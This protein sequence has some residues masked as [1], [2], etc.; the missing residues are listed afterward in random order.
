VKNTVPLIYD[1]IEIPYDQDLKFASF[2]INN[3]YANVPMNEL[4]QIIDLMCDQHDIK[5][6]MKHERMKISQTLIKQNYFQFQV[7]IFKEEE[8]LAMGAP[9]SEIYLKYIENT[10][11]FD[12][13][14]KH[15]ITWYLHYVDDI[16]KDKTNIY[17]L[18][19]IINNT[20]PSMK[21]TMEEEKEKKISFLAI[22]ISKE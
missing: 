1:I 3:M 16:L 2:D 20:M 18:L 9:T 15:H 11:I 13:L 12:I 14:L 6:D 22:T 5:E 21:F 19:N 4:I 17:D 7:T 8:G 10:K